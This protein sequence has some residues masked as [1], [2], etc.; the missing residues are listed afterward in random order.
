MPATITSPRQPDESQFMSRYLSL[1][2]E[3]D[4]FPERTTESQILDAA[5]RCMMQFGAAKLSMVDVARVAGVSRGSVYKYFPDRETLVNAVF[6]LGF[7][8]FSRDLDA[9]M[10]ETDP[11]EDQLIAGALVVR[12]WNRGVWAVSGNGMLGQADFAWVVTWGSQP[13]MV[14]MIDILTPRIE[15]AKAR[16]EVREDLDARL[17]A[18]WV[19]RIMHS[20]STNPTIGIDADNPE[21]LA[22]FLR[23]FIVQGL[24][25]S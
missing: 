8:A 9:S 21:Q 13:A 11:L 17:A 18:E 20:L 16:G 14:Q 7:W 5:R 23:A 1:E 6:E 25:P 10:V 4:L 2:P 24:A 12:E 15:D 19:A 3:P 22:D